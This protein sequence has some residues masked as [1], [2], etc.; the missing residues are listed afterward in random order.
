[1]SRAFPNKVQD[2]LSPVKCRTALG[3]RGLNRGSRRPAVRGP[4]I[5]LTADVLP[6]LGFE[7]VRWEWL[8]RQNVLLLRTGRGV[9]GSI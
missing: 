1:M 5:P 6:E 4:R 2:G 8:V 9:G 7:G 3:C